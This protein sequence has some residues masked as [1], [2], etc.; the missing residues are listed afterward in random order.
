MAVFLVVFGA[1][2]FFVKISLCSHIVA[3]R[4]VKTQTFIWLYLALYRIS[5]QFKFSIDKH[6]A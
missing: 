1:L 6:F 5:L 2:L 3:Y 4:L